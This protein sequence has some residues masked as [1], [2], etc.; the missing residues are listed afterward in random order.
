MDKNNL[1]LRIP[2]FNAD[3][4]IFRVD[5][6]YDV[7]QII[8]NKNVKY[9]VSSVIPNNFPDF[10]YKIKKIS[11]LAFYDKILISWLAI[12]SLIAF[13]FILGILSQTYE[14]YLL[15]INIIW[16]YFS[17]PVFFICLSLIFWLIPFINYHSFNKK[18]LSQ[19]KN[20]F[21]KMQKGGYIDSD[22]TKYPESLQMAFYEYHW[23]DWHRDLSHYLRHWV[24][25][26]GFL[27]LKYFFWV[28]NNLE[29]PVDEGAKWVSW[30]SKFYGHYYMSEQII[31]RVFYNND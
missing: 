30:F 19:L 17:L 14:M 13:F 1:S 29:F 22:I 26:Y 12:S 15:S 4:D 3:L 2:I 28:Y 5:E 8:I 31:N 24:S 21:I 18:Y 16:G 25:Y 20:L 11:P 27:A 7:R 23:F 9:D 6:S 10:F